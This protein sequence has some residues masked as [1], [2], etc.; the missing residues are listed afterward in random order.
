MVDIYTDQVHYRCMLEGV[1]EAD[2]AVESILAYSKFVVTYQMSPEISSPGWRRGDVEG[3]VYL[4]RRRSFPRYRIV[5]VNQFG[6]EDLIDSV[7]P[8]WELDC[9]ANYVFYK[10]E[11]ATEHIRGLWFHDDAHRLRMQTALDH[12]LQE[13]RCSG[14]PGL[15]PPPIGPAAQHHGSYEDARRQGNAAQVP[16]PG[17]LIGQRG[18]VFCSSAELQQALRDLVDDDWFLSILMRELHDNVPTRQDH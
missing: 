8:E 18:G 16:T 11:S 15:S 1:R 10:V 13:L 4:V 17:A 9:Q 12:V 3:P 2:P 5:I 14:P 6:E 7:H